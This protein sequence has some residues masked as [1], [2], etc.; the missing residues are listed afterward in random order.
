MEKTRHVLSRDPLVVLVAVLALPGAWLAPATALTTSAQASAA[1]SRDKAA[2]TDTVAITGYGFT[3]NDSAIVYGEFRLH[4]AAGYSSKRVQVAAAA[5][6]SGVVRAAITV[7]ASTVP[8]F[9]RITIKDF[10]NLSASRVLTVLQLVRLQVSA[11]PPTYVIRAD[12]EFYVEGGG[13]QA[14]ETV[15]IT[16]DFPLYNGNTEAV[17]KT[18]TADSKGNLHEVLLA[19]PRDAMAQSVTLTAS[20]SSKDG[21]SATITVV[22][23]PFLT[24]SASSVRPGQSTTVTGYGFVPNS[25]VAV[26]LNVAD[27]NGNTVTATRTPTTSYN[28]TFSVSIAL[29]TKMRTGLYKV[30]AVDS[31]GKFTA[32]HQLAVSLQPAVQLSPA[33]VH[34]GQTVKVV[35]GGY[36]ANATITVSVTFALYGGGAKTVTTT[37][38]TGPKGNFA[39]SITVPGRAAA[40]AYSVT[41]GGPNAQEHAQ[42]VVSHVGAAI[43]LST[44]SVMPGSNLIIRGFGYPAGDKVDISAPVQTTSG[45]AT[46]LNTSATAG[47]NGQFS[48]TLHIPSDAASGSYTVTAASESTGRAPTARFSV[49]FNPSIV[50]QS[51]AASPGGS[52]VLTGSGFPA[53]DKIDVALTVNK[54]GGGNSTLTAMA[55]ANGRGQFSVVIAIPTST[56][57]GTYTVSARS[58]S[59]GRSLSARLTVATL[60]PSVVVVPASAAAPGTPVTLNIFGFPAGVQISLYVG[61]SKLTTVTANK[62]GQ[63]TT[64]V[65]LPTS[66]AT[67]SYTVT[68]AGS[69][70]RKAYVALAVQRAVST[71]YYFASL[72]TGTGYHE[73]LTFLN[74]TEIKTQVTVTYE[75]TT[76][77]VKTR[78]FSINPHSRSTEDVNADLGTHVSSAAAV[79]ADVPIVAERLVMHGT[80]AALVP[81]A[82]TPASIWYFANGNTSGKYREYV[83]VQNPNKSTIQVWA[84]ILPTHHA[85]FTVTRTMAPT[86]R[87]TFNIKSYVRD[88]V[89][90]TI[91]AS[92]PVVAN[93]SMFI[94][95]GMTSKIG[96]TAPQ[97]TWYFAGG[98]LNGAAHYW[99][100]VVN[101]SNHWSRLSIHAYAPSGQVVG[102]VSSWLK[103]Y[104][105]AGYLVN[106]IA[107]RTDV[108]VVLQ[109]SRPSVAE[110][111]SYAGRMHNASTDSFGVSSPAKSWGFAAVDTVS[112]LGARDVLQL[113]NPSLLA[114]PIVVQFMTASGGVTQR[115]YVV[116]PLGQQTIDVGSVVPNAELGIVATSNDPFVA[117]NRLI[118]NNGLGADTSHGIHI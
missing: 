100:G 47:S 10:H 80:S 109:S 45:A 40:G 73:Y 75:P 108:S 44:S 2:P 71:H 88:A 118:V 15:Q 92:A 7:P 28:G 66:L 56:A 60:K 62:A 3:A 30:T 24:L 27:N 93:R 79:S 61:N 31:T 116:G 50:L 14:G 78:T 12:H 115:T 26:T 102:T 77:A 99:L 114:E 42:L 63:A 11:K 64:K 69:G 13:F 101:T 32:S 90:V 83:A 23:I 53:G 6:G 59:T 37:A 85:A 9:Y 70:G 96:V 106:K 29:P 55:T 74:P 65:T 110:Q 67:G 34:P 98:P 8:G 112:A 19:V 22:Y 52:A 54:V 20:G 72:Y 17:N 16:A 107:H 86:S 25:V 33:T 87:T 4:T 36:S 57:G 113:F 82:T 81:G 97:R 38:H 58:S 5:N 35:G 48:A 41:A 95:H 117:L 76:G 103:P 84:R 21:A 51:A 1:L 39:T 91:T 43:A 111:T 94:M 105:R 18:V 68:A 89:G 49:T 46:T 104:A